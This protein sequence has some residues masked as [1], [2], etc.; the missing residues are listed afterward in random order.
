MPHEVSVIIPTRNRAKFLKAA[1]ESVLSQRDCL[2]EL[3]VVDHESTDNTADVL[4]SLPKPAKFV[5]AHISG[6]IGPSRPKN[7][8]ADL[9]TK[10]FITFFDSDDIMADEAL[11]GAISVM[12][13]RKSHAVFSRIV[14]TIDKDGMPIHETSSS[15]YFEAKYRRNRLNTRLSSEEVANNELQG[16]ATLVYRKEAF[17]VT[18]R[19]DESLEQA[20]DFDFAYRFSRKHSIEFADV[21]YL[22]YRV[23]DSNLS[24]HRRGNE[25]VSNLSTS[26]WHKQARAKL[27]LHG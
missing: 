12:L 11:A 27:G 17:N 22:L 19:F 9:A 5:T 24:V 18:G 4:R 2:I 25:V 13:E 21:P 20:E 26:R 23:H 6:G 10:E 14:G 16:Y 8:G 1:I 15:R 7:I 3:I